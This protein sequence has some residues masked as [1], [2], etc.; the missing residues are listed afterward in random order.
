MGRARFEVSTEGMRE[1]QSGREPWQLAKE[2]IANAWDESSTRCEVVIKS[3]APRKAL[4]SVYDDGDGFANIADA[5]TLMGHTPKRGNPSVRGRFNIGEKEI[6]SVA[7][8]AAIYTSG[9]IIRFPKSGGRQVSTNGNTLK[10]TRVDCHMSWGNRQ[11]EVVIANLKKLLTPKDIAYT[12]NGEV[13]TYQ[14]PQ[15]TIEATL[16]TVLQ[17]APNEPMRVTR[18][19]TQLEICPSEQGILYEM[20]IPIQPVECPYLVNVMQKVPMPPNRDVVRDS[21]LQDIYTAVLNATAEGVEEP[22]ATWVR[23]AIEDK[24][25]IPEA[26]KT[27]IEKR[28]G[29][30]V[31]LY[32]SDHHSNER[33]M[34]AGYEIVHGRTLSPME[35]AAMG[36][37]GLAH[38]SDRFPTTYGEAK[39]VTEPTDGMN[40]IADYAQRLSKALLGYNVN[41]SFYRMPKSEVAADWL[42]GYLRFNVSRL[43]KSWFDIIGA[44]QTSIILHEFAHHK[45]D[46]HNWEYQKSLEELAGKAV[47]LALAKP[48]IFKAVKL[49][50]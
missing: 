29:N 49:I 35:R 1:L 4:L 37:V 44:I 30:K 18:R 24:D 25:I 20:G 40:Q 22:S 38:S 12:V 14:T 11:V 5:W 3:L 31:V 9:K 41:V 45:G 13:I 6:L 28:Y 2:L 23:L 46:G 48:E 36:N 42:N 50:K 39:V 16:E 19:K 7:I 17:N 32:S 33:A 34:E 10:G 8:D 21:Y 26:V 27:I 47:H 43:G 15:Q